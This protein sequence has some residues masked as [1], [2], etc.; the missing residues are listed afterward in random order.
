MK[1]YL[2]SFLEPHNFGPGRII[3]IANGDKPDHVKCDVVFPPL[4]PSKEITVKYRNESLTN[5][6]NAGKNF[7]QGFKAELNSFMAE[8]KKACE[9]ESKTPQDLLPF[10]E[11]DSLCSWERAAFTNYRGIIAPYLQKLGYDVVIN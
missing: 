6:K 3:G 2:A 5:P 10:E 8:V 7:M 1:L 9:E 4:I 11:G